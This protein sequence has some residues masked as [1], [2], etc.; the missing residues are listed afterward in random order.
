MPLRHLLRIDWDVIAGIIAALVAMLLSFMGLVS[1]TDGRGI[2]LLLCALLLIRDLRG[3]AGL[4]LP[5]IALRPRLAMSADCCWNGRGVTGMKTSTRRI[6]GAALAGISVAVAV[7]LQFAG[8]PVMSMDDWRTESFPGGDF[9]SGTLQLHWQLAAVA[10]FTLLGV[11][12]FNMKIINVIIP[13]SGWCPCCIKC[14]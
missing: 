13:F 1:E 12:I 8:K 2:I 9:T 10:A 6:L 7:V 3:E 5:K 11:A 14:K 4:G